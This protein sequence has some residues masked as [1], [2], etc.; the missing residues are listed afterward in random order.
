[1]TQIKPNAGLRE[2][3][4][5]V[6]TIL[7]SDSKTDKNGDNTNFVATTATISGALMYSGGKLYLSD[8]AGVMKL[9]TSA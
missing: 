6:D 1:M 8:L 3:V 4:V 9:V 2:P 5:S 7:F